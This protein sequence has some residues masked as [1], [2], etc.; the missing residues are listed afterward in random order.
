MSEERTL[1]VGRRT[2]TLSRPEKV[3][4]PAAGVTKAE[5]ADYYVAVA[6]A[7]L[8]HLRGRPLALERCPDGIAG[9][10]IFQ[11]NVPGY[12]PAWIHR[13]TVEKEG[14][15]LQQV[16]CDDAATLVYLADQ[17]CVT[18]HTWLS[19]IDEPRTPDI[20]VFD[21]D[22]P[23]NDFEA[24]RSAALAVHALLD[25]LELPAYAKTTGKRGVHVEVPLRRDA[26]FDEVRAFAREVARELVARHPDRLTIEQHRDRRDGRLYLDLMRNGYA[27][28]AVAPYAVRA[29]PHASVATPLEWDEVADPSLRPDA[30]TV[31]TVPQRLADGRQPW[32]GMRRRAR[33]L[34]RARERLD[35][36][37]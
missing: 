23:G 16:V 22:P 15:T 5:L 18:A 28:T 2:V 8:P 1:R 17:A 10:R 36:L 26:D 12:Y 19:R 35:T 25:E 33:G 29:L 24:A 21:L 37:A 32:R 7:M 14:G 11:K 31:R 9:E 30:F 27:Q 13:A 20:L 34:A 3:L 4:F 6:E